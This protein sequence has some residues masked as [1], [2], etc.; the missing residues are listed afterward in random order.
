MGNPSFLPFPPFYLQFRFPLVY[1]CFA[2]SAEFLFASVEFD[3]I[4]VKAG[5]KLQQGAKQE[6]RLGCW[7]K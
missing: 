4:V 3:V 1:Q 6:K 7:P 2:A 5:S